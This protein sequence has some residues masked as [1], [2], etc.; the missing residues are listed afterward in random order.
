MPHIAEQ[1]E[2]MGIKSVCKPNGQECVAGFHHDSI[3]LPNGHIIAIGTLER[4]IPAGAQG[5]DDPV[6]IAGTIIID[7]DQ[8]MQV[9]WFWNSFRP[10]G[11]E[12]QVQGGQQVPRAGRQSG[13]R[14]VFLT[15]HRQRLAARQRLS[16]TREDGNLTLSMPE[17][18]WVIKIDYDHG[19]GSGKSLEAR[20]GRR[21]QSRIQRSETLVFLSA[22]CRIRAP[23]SNMLVL[24]DNG[25]RRVEKEKDK[26]GKEKDKDPDSRGQ[27]WRIDEKARTATWS[28]NADLGSLR[29]RDG[30]AHRLSN[31][32]YHFTRGVRKTTPSGRRRSK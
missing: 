22:R 19:K 15:T 7:L 30:T 8:E 31:G 6:N 9:K 14:A 16:Y 24:L 20:R 26:D 29:A 11:S 28:M 12:T 2:S 3:G 17:Q 4:V 1:L 10:P 21:F 27:V 25:H 23:G 18:D 13:M 5:S 32:N